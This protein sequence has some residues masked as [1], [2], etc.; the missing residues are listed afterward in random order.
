M[1]AP[2]TSSGDRAAGPVR[3]SLTV[4]VPALNEE[5]N[6]RPTVEAV[7]AHLGSIADPLEVL[8]FDDAS[9]DST[10]AVA[11]ALA[12]RHAAV[13]AF[14][15]PRRLNI[16]GVYKAGLREARG[17]WVVLVPGDN[18]TRVD[19][20]ARGVAY[21]GR[22]PLVVF[23]VTNTGVRPWSRRALSRL[24]V[25]GVNALFGTR[26]RYTN[27]TNLVRADVARALGIRTDG[28]AYQTE[29]L[30]R[31]LRSG[32][33][34]VQVGLR[35]QE[36]RF[37]ASKAVSWTNLRAVGAALARLWWDVRVRERRRYRG[38]GR[39]LGTY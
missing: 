34:C 8:V 21:V 36:R 35:I 25:W 13:R 2:A 15:N 20:I 39:V 3:L 7:L 29:A 33:D 12:A 28:F 17:A 18:E 6:L 11:D 4:I 5:A 27:G 38:R 23:Y 10:G 24:Y 19:E 37:G 30:V 22:A 31:A 32:V 1:S 14:H 9:T 26:L 16:G